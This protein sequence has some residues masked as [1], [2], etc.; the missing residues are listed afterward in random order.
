MINTQKRK[1]YSKV[2]I[3]LVVSLL[4]ANVAIKDIFLANTPRVSPNWHNNVLVKFANLLNVPTTFF[5][6]LF[7]GKT[8]DE[9]LKNVP[10]H[11]VARGVYAKQLENKSLKFYKESEVEWLT[12]TFVHNGKTYTIRYAAGENPPNEEL[13]KELLD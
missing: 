3:A 8:L 4:I 10:Y 1:Y 5:A 2:L 7:R 9:E 13:L 11:P 6:G 12:Y